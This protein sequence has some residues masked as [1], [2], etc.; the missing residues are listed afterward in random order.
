MKVP[1][2]APIMCQIVSLVIIANNK[3]V[4]NPTIIALFKSKCFHIGIRK[5]KEIVLISKL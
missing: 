5:F 2:N 1:E 4:I 3:H